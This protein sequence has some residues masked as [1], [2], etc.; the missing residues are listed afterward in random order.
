MKFLCALSLITAPLFAQPNS[1]SGLVD[2]GSGIADNKYGRTN[3]LGRLLLSNFKYAWQ[4]TRAANGDKTFNFIVYKCIYTLQIATPL[5]GGFEDIPLPFPVCTQLAQSGAEDFGTIG[6]GLGLFNSLAP[7]LVAHNVVYGP[8]AD[9]A[10]PQ[11]TVEQPATPP[12]PEMIMFDGLGSNMMKFDLT[13]FAILSQVPMFPLGVTTF[14]IRPAATGAENEVWTAYSATGAGGVT[15]GGITIV[16]LTTNSVAASIPNTANIAPVNIVF[17][18]SGNTA[19]EAVSYPKP[20]SSGN[21]GAILVFDAVSRTLTSTLPLKNAPQ[22]I[23][24]APDGLT[25]YILGNN[26]TIT[27]YDVLSGTADLTAPFPLAFVT[28]TVFLHPDGTR[29][30][31]DQGY[32]LGV[33]DLT[34]RQITNTFNYNLAMYAVPMSVNMSQDGSTVWVVDTVNNVTILDTR[35]GNILAVYQTSSGSTVFPGPAY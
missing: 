13:T 16:D 34:T 30:F 11:L 1:G 2:F 22:Q 18:N 3:G 6:A 35:Y 15:A 28:G 33:F 20:D 26:F 23:L 32:G 9:R 17:T 14:G 27:Y 8:F 21:N 12:D 19:L 4:I 29:L 5:I 25:A 7:G 31:V 10:R 24:M